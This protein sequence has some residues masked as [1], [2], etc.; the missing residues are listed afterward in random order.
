M[1]MVQLFAVLCLLVGEDQQNL[2]TLLYRT[3]KARDFGSGAAGRSSLTPIMSVN[4]GLSIPSLPCVELGW[5]PWW[6]DL[7]FDDC[8]RQRA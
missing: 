2:S 7:F 5:Q 3:T 1:A 8:V 4:F 6:A